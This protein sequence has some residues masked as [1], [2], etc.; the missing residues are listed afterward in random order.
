HRSKV[1]FHEYLDV[2]ILHYPIL[3]CT[4][5][6]TAI[7]ASAKRCQDKRSLTTSHAWGLGAFKQQLNYT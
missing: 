6:G 1:S 5:L 2:N 3:Y 4:Q 7:V